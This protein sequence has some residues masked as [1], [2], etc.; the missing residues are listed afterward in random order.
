MFFNFI[1]NKEN[2]KSCVFMCCINQTIHFGME[3]AGK[4]V[5]LLMRC[6]K[7]NENDSGAKL[8]LYYS[9]EKRLPLTKN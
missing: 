1:S 6:A 8:Q 4:V 3:R 2:K 9:S 5:D 7:A